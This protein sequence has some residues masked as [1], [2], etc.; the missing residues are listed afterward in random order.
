MVE[1]ATRLDWFKSDCFSDD[2]AP[3]FLNSMMTIGPKHIGK[4][5][6]CHTISA[7]AN[8]LAPD[9]VGTI[10]LLPGEYNMG[11]HFNQGNID[12]VAVGEVVVAST[13]HHTFAFFGTSNARLKGLTIIQG[14]HTLD[15]DSNLRHALAI[16]DEAS[17]TLDACNVSNACR[18]CIGLT[19]HAKLTSTAVNI[20]DLYGAVVVSGQARV[21]CSK[22]E[23]TN[24]RY[25][26]IEARGGSTLVVTESKF[27]CVVLVFLL[28]IQRCVRVALVMTTVAP[29][30]YVVVQ[31]KLLLT[32]H[33]VRRA[34]T[35]NSRSRS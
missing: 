18:L 35:A 24:M 12:V 10:I 28:Q 9:I 1:L 8:M 34:T 14:Y 20:Y 33:L 4:L 30:R 25:G 3:R 31:L 15:I 29:C 7:G 23:I 22:V 16:H 27:I 6:D 26:G 2:F 5:V 17:V 21:I 11:C 19:D 13:E 32:A